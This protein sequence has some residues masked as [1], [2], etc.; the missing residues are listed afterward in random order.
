[1]VLWKQ[2]ELL[3]VQILTSFQLV[4]VNSDK[5]IGKSHAEHVLIEVE[6]VAF[7]VDDNR[8]IEAGWFADCD[9]TLDDEEHSV[10]VVIWRLD[11]HTLVKTAVGHVDD[12]LDYKVA[13]TSL[14]NV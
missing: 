11:H 6:N 7:L 2:N 12:Y 1:M 5:L 8:L 13:R 4:R 10:N 14:E 3:A 9:S